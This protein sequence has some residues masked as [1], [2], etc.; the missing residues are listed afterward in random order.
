[1]QDESLNPGTPTYLPLKSEIL[2]IKLLEKKNHIYHI[3]H[4]SMI[5][6]NYASGKFQ[7]INNINAMT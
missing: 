3:Y 7:T 2:A 4:T 1:M 5:R 6:S